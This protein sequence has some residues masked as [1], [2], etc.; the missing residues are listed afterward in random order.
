MRGS[1]Q[2]TENAGCTIPS[3]GCVKAVPLVHMYS[4]SS[5]ADLRVYSIA[6]VALRQKLA[7]FAVRNACELAL[8]SRLSLVAERV[9][10]NT[11]VDI[12]H[13]V[14]SHPWLLYHCIPRKT[15]FRCSGMAQCF[16][17]V[18]KGPAGHCIQ[19]HGVITFEHL[20]KRFP[21]RVRPIRL[22]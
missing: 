3:L 8:S 21:P 11:D 5:S 9:R 2:W 12:F 20:W 1:F 13:P 18:M 22:A 16:H 17:E 19:A 15:D 14:Y 4:T 6:R 7:C 10:P